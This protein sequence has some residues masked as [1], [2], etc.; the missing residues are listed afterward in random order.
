VKCLKI[1]GFRKNAFA[2]NPQGIV[3]KAWYF[4]VFLGIRL[5]LHSAQAIFAK[6]FASMLII[7]L[8]TRQVFQTAGEPPSSGSTSRANSGWIMNRSVALTKSVIANRTGSA[9]NPARFGDLCGWTGGCMTMIGLWRLT[10]FPGEIPAPNPTTSSRP[11]LPLALGLLL[12]AVR[13]PAQAANPADPEAIDRLV[14][15]A[16]KAWQVPSVAVGIVRDG[17][18][19]YLKGH[20]VRAAGG[21]DPVTPDTLFPIASCTKAFTT[22]ALA[23]LVDE[24]KLSWDDPVRKH[25]PFFR[26]ADPL[27][28]RDV[29]LRDLVCHRTGLGNHDLLWYRSPWTQEE[30][31]RRAGLLP[32]DRPF[33]TAFQYQST[34]FTAAGLAAAKA[35]ETSWSDFVQKRL[36]DPLQMKRTVFTSTAAQDLE[37][38]DGHRIN[39]I[40]EV[41][42]MPG[43]VME[44]PDPAGSIHTCA[45]DLCHWLL[46]QLGDGQVEGQRLVSARGLEETHTPQMV[47]PMQGLPRRMHPETVQLSYG[48]G[49]VIQDYQ[50]QMLWSHAG[51]I[52]GFRAHLT[53]VPRTGLGIVLLDNLHQTHMNLALSNS[54]LDLLLDLPKRDWNSYLLDVQRD[55]KRQQA[56]QLRTRQ[57]QR[58]LGTKPSLPLTDYAGAYEHPAY[59][60]V[61]VAPAGRG[62]LVWRWNRFVCPLEH[63]QYDTFVLRDDVLDETRVQFHLGGDGMVTALQTSGALQVEFKRVRK[64]NSK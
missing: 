44:V 18:V 30:S 6:W 64:G 24:G 37:P 21:K 32:L 50:G 9:K 61:E 48:M 17:R 7:P 39:R 52:D 58:K 23:I 8:S 16:L 41:E 62:A 43:Y 20:G 5:V 15:S 10:P 56:D 45:R 49:W 1:Q 35:A 26:L 33:R 12:L 47:I 53:L 31:I 36:L 27:A 55:E 63:Y 54:L 59:G 11:C 42:P 4:R 14:R 19:L 46:F 22:T 28:D 34:M 13:A 38:A 57:Q 40:G 25:V 2:G 60:R 29:T 3:G 51:V